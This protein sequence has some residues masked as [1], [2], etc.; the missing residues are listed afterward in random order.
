MG[1]LRGVTKQQT[2]ENPWEGIIRGSKENPHLI[3][4]LY[5]SIPTNFLTSCLRMPHTS[6][7]N[8]PI[9]DFLLLSL[10]DIAGLDVARGCDEVR[11]E[12]GKSFASDS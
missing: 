6:L 1:A 3:P 4:S 8:L 2:P 5:L 9:H 7:A 11:R 10:H 12:L